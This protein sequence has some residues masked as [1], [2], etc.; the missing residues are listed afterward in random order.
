[1]LNFKRYAV[2]IGVSVALML[3][4]YQY[5]HMKGSLSEQVRQE[6]VIN[7]EY[8]KKVTADVELHNAV[9]TALDEIGKKHADEM[10]ELEGS[11]DGIINGLSRDNKRLYVK[12]K[13]SP[14]GDSTGSGECVTTVNGEAELDSGTAASIIKVT[15]KGDK[16]IENLQATIIELQKKENK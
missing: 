11:T 2:A 16:W 6:E 10:A 8:I 5:G 7:H 1:M 12:L 4:S 14:T 9:Q 3:G 13:A 15:Q